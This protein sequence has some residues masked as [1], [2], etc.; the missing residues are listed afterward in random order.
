VFARA[1]GWAVISIRRRVRRQLFQLRA[2][3]RAKF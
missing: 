3:V 1:N 2:L